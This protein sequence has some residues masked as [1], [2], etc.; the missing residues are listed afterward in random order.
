MSTPGYQPSASEVKTL[1]DRTDLPMMECKKALVHAKGDLEQ[2]IKYLREQGEKIQSNKAGRETSQGRIEVYRD[3]NG[4]V[5]SIVQMKCEQ[6]PSAKNEKFVEM[7]KALAR[8]A[9]LQPAEPTVDSILE[10]PDVDT[11]SIQANARLLAVI[12]LIRENMGLARVG[13]LKAD[14]GVLGA[15]VHFDYQQGAVIRLQGPGATAELANDIATHAVATKPLAIRREDIPKDLVDREREI[16]RKQAEQ[17][18]K[19]ANLLD[20][21]AEGKLNAFFAENSLLEQVFVKD[22]TKKVRDL[23]GGNITMT[24]MIRYRV[25]EEG[26]A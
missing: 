3:P 20:K 13:R 8:Q 6:A 1:R 25:G 16:G 12:N 17:S 24:H 18:G 5:I 19:P 7:T 4:Q 22:N 23:L 11:P 15:Y 26:S 10:Q 14:G 21:I 9:A 2:A